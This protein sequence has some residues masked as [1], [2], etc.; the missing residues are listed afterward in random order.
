MTEHEMHL[1][2]VT[3]DRLRAGFFGDPRAERT[4]RSHLDSCA[5]CRS[6]VARWDGVARALAPRFEVDAVVARELARR[7]GSVLS[8]PATG[9]GR[10]GWRWSYAAAALAAALV[11]VVGVEIGGRAVTPAEPV[12][13]A[14]ARAPEFFSDIE[15]YVWLAKRAEDPGQGS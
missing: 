4:A 3:I 5:A 10:T 13:V 14:D 11:V 2:S 8:G 6:A 15:F 9:T 7:R 1:D 12:A